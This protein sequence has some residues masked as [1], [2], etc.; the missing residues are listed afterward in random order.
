MRISPLIKPYRT[1][2]GIFLLAYVLGYFAARRERML[3]HQVSHAGDVY[4]HSIEASGLYAWSSLGYFVPVSYIVFSPLRWSEA[5][6]WHF[7]PTH[8]EILQ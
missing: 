4:H 2:L 7:I 8:Y 1:A 3:I 5:L 6:I